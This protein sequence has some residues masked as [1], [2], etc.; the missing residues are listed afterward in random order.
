MVMEKKAAWLR[1]FVPTALS[2]L[3]AGSRPSTDRL[4]LPTSSDTQYSR[5]AVSTALLAFLFTFTTMV[6]LPATS[7]L[8]GLTMAAEQHETLVIERATAS[9]PL[10]FTVEVARTPQ[11]QALGLMFR[12]EL[13]AMHGML[14][15]YAQPK[16]ITM[17]MKNTFIPLDMVFIKQNGE[18][19]RIEEMTEP[20]S[21]RVISSGGDATGVLEIAGGEARRLGIARGDMVR[22]SHFDSQR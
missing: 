19:L 7:P 6:L 22:H 16:V 1:S 12:R 10:T 17:W 15:P 21:E 20:F 5:R 4:N 3:S 9:E 11:R 18:V 14:F 8:I 2:L 13:P